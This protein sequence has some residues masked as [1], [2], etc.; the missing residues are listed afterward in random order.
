MMTGRHH[1]ERSA[2]VYTKRTLA[3]YDRWVLGFSNRYVWRCQTEHLLELYRRHLTDNHLE[4]GPGTGRLLA[5]TLPQL[6]GPVRRCALV[7]LNPDCL[8]HASAELAAHGPERHLA[9]L[10]QPLE[11][12]GPRFAS[13][14]LNYVLHCLPGPLEEKSGNVFDHLRDHLEDDGVLF[15][16]TLLGKDIQIPLAA[17]PLMAAYNRMGVFDNGEDSLG[18]LMESLSQRFRTFHV[19]V[20]GCGVLF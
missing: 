7:D 18:G 13:I 2:S 1:S 6:P 3:L 8:D 9:D 11:L 12:P 16:S 4:A 10:L 15:G 19:E 14:A 17:R 5:D 20:H